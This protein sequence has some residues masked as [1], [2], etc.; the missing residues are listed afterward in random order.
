MLQL[1]Q[2]LDRLLLLLKCN[3]KKL[4]TVKGRSL[5]INVLSQ[6]FPQTRLFPADHLYVV[7][8][9]GQEQLRCSM[10]DKRRKD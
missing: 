9:N 3:S 10:D 7:H 8:V 4:D 2:L 6:T 5:Q 1:D